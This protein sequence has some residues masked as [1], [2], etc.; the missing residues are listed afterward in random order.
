[1]KSYL[2]DAAWILAPEGLFLSHHSNYSANPGSPSY[3]LN[4]HARNHMSHEL[5]KSI[6]TGA[7]LEIVEGTSITWGGVSNLDRVT[8]LQRPALRQ[9]T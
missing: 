7:H 1:M 6:A 9:S 8:L 3:G 4:P 5:L 2:N